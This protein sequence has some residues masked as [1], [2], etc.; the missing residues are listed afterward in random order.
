MRSWI[1]SCLVLV[2]VAAT[3]LV[4]CALTPRR[5]D[6]VFGLYRDRMKGDKL[7][8][9][10]KL[11]TEESRSLAEEL[12]TEF[13][14]SQYPENLALLNILDPMSSP[15]MVKEEEDFALLQ[16]RTLRG[17]LRVVRLVR[18][19]A[20]APWQLDLAPELKA[21]RTFLSL[22]DALEMMRE[23]A[24]EYSSSSRSFDEQLG[25]M[26]PPV[27]DTAKRQPPSKPT[28]KPKR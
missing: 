13:K 4:G 3:C 9:A 19:D 14:L 2:V 16:V 21:L 23:Q 24:S 22:R 1:S 11:V 10:R 20:R 6:A 17:G 25:R 18:K 5:A 26:H 7:A 27:P 12:S 28:P 8:E 15:V